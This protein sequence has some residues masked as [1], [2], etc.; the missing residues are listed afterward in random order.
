MAREIFETQCG[1]LKVPENPLQLNPTLNFVRIYTY[2][3]GLPR[4]K[5]QSKFLPRVQLNQFGVD[6][7]G[8]VEQRSYY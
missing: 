4:S 3:I 2:L 8:T 5:I 7:L 1:C 6:F